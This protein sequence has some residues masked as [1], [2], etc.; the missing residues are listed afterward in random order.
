MGRRIATNAFRT[1]PRAVA[2]AQVSGDAGARETALRELEEELGL[3]DA[4]AI[5]GAL[6]HAFAAPHVC[7]GST[8]RH[9]AYV[10]RELVDV[11]TLAW[12]PAV[13]RAF[14]ADPGAALA[15]A[16]FTVG[17]GEVSALK[18]VD[19]AHV[20]DLLRRK[21]D[22]LVPRAPYYVDAVADALGQPRG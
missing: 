15:D 8:P 3:R 12:S 11:F 7:A 9:G 19:A 10:D 16:S 18:I 4:A 13:A 2:R 6:V 21:D 17:A 1:T 14:G 22:S 20:L 5:G